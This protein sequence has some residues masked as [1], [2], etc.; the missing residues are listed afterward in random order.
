[1]TEDFIAGAAKE[2][3]VA[4]IS[5]GTR[6]SDSKGGKESTEEDVFVATREL[7]KTAKNL[8]FSSFRG[9]DVDRIVSFDKACKA[10]GRTLV[11]LRRSRSCWKSSRKTSI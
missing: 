6:V 2:K 5:E 9:N 1:M 4:L 10:A 7:L 8:V 3:P 11:V